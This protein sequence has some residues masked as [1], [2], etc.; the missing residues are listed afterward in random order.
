MRDAEALLERDLPMIPVYFYTRPT[1]RAP[2]VR[3]WWPNPL[4]FHPYKYVWLEN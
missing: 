1:L 4:D 2:S 3:G